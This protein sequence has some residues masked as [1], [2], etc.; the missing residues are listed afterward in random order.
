MSQREQKLATEYT[1]LWHAARDAATEIVER[2]SSR[3]ATYPSAPP[4]RVQQIELVRANLIARPLHAQDAVRNGWPP[5]M[6]LD[7]LPRERTIPAVGRRRVLFRAL[8]WA[9]DLED[10][11][12]SDAQWITLVPSY[13]PDAASLRGSVRNARLWLEQY[14]EQL[15]QMTASRLL[16]FTAIE[17]AFWTQGPY[18]RLL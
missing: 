2:I 17:I 15:H 5:E 12:A 18:A 16:V 4:A 10:Q 3:R 6:L 8:C 13:A 1:S 7:S 14:V 9:V 11:R